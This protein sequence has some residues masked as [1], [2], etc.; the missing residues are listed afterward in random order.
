MA[1]Y[2][3]IYLLSKILLYLPNEKL[4]LRFSLLNSSFYDAVRNII[5][6]TQ[7]AKN[8]KQLKEA[9][10]KL[11]YIRLYNSTKLYDGKRWRTLNK[12]YGLQGA[13]ISSDMFL[14]N[15]MINNSTKSCTTWTKAI[16]GAS[17][18]GNVHVLEYILIKFMENNC[19]KVEN[20]VMINGISR[21]L[22]YKIHMDNALKIAKTY[23][24]INSPIVEFIGRYIE[25]HGD[26]KGYY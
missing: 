24:S 5:K 8:S 11:Q 7:P 21:C 17:Q 9:C 25:K 2:L 22:S 10:S 3:P 20:S 12:D 6:N 26:P 13:C 16:S 18:G 14:I 4:I 15:M 19:E 23:H 1:D